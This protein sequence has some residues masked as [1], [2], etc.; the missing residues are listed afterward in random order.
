MVLLCGSSF[1]QYIG[2]FDYKQSV[3]INNGS[4]LGDGKLTYLRRTAVSP[5]THGPQHQPAAVRMLSVCSAHE[6]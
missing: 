6:R 2:A 5:V 1:E 3:N 4:F